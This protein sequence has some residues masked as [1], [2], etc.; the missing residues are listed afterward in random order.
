[1][2]NRGV[3]VHTKTAKVVLFAI[4]SAG[5]ASL[6]QATEAKTVPSPW[7]ATQCELAN[8]LSGEIAYAV[9]RK[10]PITVS[11]IDNSRGRRLTL[12]SHRVSI[13]TE[14]GKAVFGWDQI[15]K[16]EVSK[17]GVVNAAYGLTILTSDGTVLGEPF[18]VVEL[19][20]LRKLEVLL[21]KYAP[22]K[23]IGAPPPA[24]IRVVPG[25]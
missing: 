5:A 22:G 16:V 8:A 15:R 14:R 1:M 21:A 20:C 10:F 24:D 7:W 13:A 25:R 6:C 17:I 12:D 18:G 9:F 23:E 11:S 19:T 4:V 2:R 3:P